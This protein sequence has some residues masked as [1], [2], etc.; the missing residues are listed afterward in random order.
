M[1]EIFEAGGQGE[2]SQLRVIGLGMGWSH[3]RA[4]AMEEK[5]ELKAVVDIDEALAKQRAQEK[6]AN[7]P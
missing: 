7:T 5:S 4:I 3:A 2:E 1:Y 6:K